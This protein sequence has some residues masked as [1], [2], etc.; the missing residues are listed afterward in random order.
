MF[1]LTSLSPRPEAEKRQKDALASWKKAGLKGISLNFPE[2]SANIRRV[3]PELADVGTA[4]H[5]CLDEEGRP[6]VAVA[7]LI[8]RSF[9]QNKGKSSFILNA[10]IVL[11]PQFGPQL[12]GSPQ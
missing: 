5:R 7:E 9:V 6:H 2:E 12:F 8:E 1:V 4:Y 3:Y 10:D 11:S